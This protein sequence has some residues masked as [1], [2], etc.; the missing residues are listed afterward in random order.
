MWVRQELYQA[1]RR[2][3]EFSSALTA[4]RTRVVRQLLTESVLLSP[5]GA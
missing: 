2:Q 1:R 5:G 4:E 3:R